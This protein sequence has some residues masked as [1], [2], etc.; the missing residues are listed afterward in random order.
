MD[1]LMGLLEP[2]LVWSRHRDRACF[3]SE[4]SHA[5]TLV[6]MSPTP[7]EALSELVNSGLELDRRELNGM[8]RAVWPLAHGPLFRHDAPTLTT[9]FERAGYVSD[10]VAYPTD[11]LIVY[12]GDLVACGQPGISWTTN[13]QVAKTYAQGYSTM[14]NV[15]V[16]QA[17][18]PPLA[19]LARFKHEDEVVVKP[20]LLENIEV[21]GYLPRFKLSLAH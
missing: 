19:V 7:S 8:L 13:F 21:K 6:V 14:G 9:L 12:R 2:Q 4:P 16:L 10:G 1:T 5:A 3:P 18:A 17:S 20:E 11:D 15:Q